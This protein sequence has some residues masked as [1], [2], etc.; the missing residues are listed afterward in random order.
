MVSARGVLP[1]R[2]VD[3]PG[4]AVI[5]CLCGAEAATLRKAVTQMAG[6]R[7]AAPL[8]GLSPDITP[9]A[10]LNMIIH[11]RSCAAA[12]WLAAELERSR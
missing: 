4:G 1:L 8:P 10:V 6:L 7:A 11:A 2:V 5:R 3:Q 12:R 9:A